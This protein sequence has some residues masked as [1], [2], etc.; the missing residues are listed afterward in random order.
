MSSRASK[1]SEPIAAADP[2]W[3]SD[4]LGINL[5][6]EGETVEIRDQSFL[7]RDGILRARSLLSD[8]QAQT[9]DAFGFKWAKRDTFESAAS[10]ERI[11][12]WLLAKYGNVAEATWCKDRGPIQFCSMQAAARLS[13]LALFSE[14]LRPRSVPWRGRLRRGRDGCPRFAERG[15][16]RGIHPG[17]FDDLPISE[18]R[19]ISSSPKECFTTPTTER[20]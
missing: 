1:T 7:R 13:A 20:A 19:S 3:L 16:Q 17:R 6:Q 2:E 14:R 12:A 4:L 5:P 10:L 8:E 9:S 11:N 18:D 15:I